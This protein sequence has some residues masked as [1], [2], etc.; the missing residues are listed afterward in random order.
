MTDEKKKQIAAALEAGARSV[1]PEIARAVVE[2]EAKV[3]PLWEKLGDGRDE[4]R[5]LWMILQDAVS[6]VCRD[7]PWNFVAAAAAAFAYLIY[8]FD[9]IPDFIPLS[10]Y[11]DDI[12]MLDWVVARFA[13]VIDGCRKKKIPARKR[14]AKHHPER[15]R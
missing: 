14:G 4:Y 12:L 15:A 1:S 3:R 8:P 13:D 2:Q 11:A 6:G 5:T 10:G 9:V 7:I